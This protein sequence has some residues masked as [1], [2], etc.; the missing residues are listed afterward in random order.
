M[1]TQAPARRAGVRSTPVSATAGM[2]LAVLPRRPDDGVPASTGVI[3]LGKGGLHQRIED[4]TAGSRSYGKEQP[5]GIYGGRHGARINVQ[6]L[7]GWIDTDRAGRARVRSGHADA[8]RCQE[9]CA[10]GP[11]TA[12]TNRVKTR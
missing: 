8:D 4:Q 1:I 9:P 3:S 5:T 2:G 6:P 7:H 10:E 12:P 11:V